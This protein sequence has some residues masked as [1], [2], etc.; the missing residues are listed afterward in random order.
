MM[1]QDQDAGFKTE[2]RDGMKIRLDVPIPMDDGVVLRR[3][4]SGQSETVS[5]S[6]AHVR[7]LRK[8]IAFQDG[9][10]DAW[11]AMVRDHPM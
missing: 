10:P 2:I 4:F 7:P 11:K 6:A 1:T 9:Y 8:R 5:A 3:T